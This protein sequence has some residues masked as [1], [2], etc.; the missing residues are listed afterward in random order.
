MRGLER[1]DVGLANGL[2]LGNGLR[3]R[4]RRRREENEAKKRSEHAAHD[5]KLAWCWR[6]EWGARQS[7]PSAGHGHA[8]EDKRQ[9]APQSSVAILSKAASAVVAV[10]APSHCAFAASIAVWHEEAAKLA[11]RHLSRRAAA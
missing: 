7:L 6:A 4:G 2:G 3:R 11:V 8:F 10:H 5:P 1:D 9:G